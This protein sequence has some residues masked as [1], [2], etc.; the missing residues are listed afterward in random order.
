[1]EFSDSDQHYLRA[2]EGWLELNEPVEAAKELDQISLPFLIDPEVLLLR[3]RI[4]LAIHRPEYTFDIATTLTQQLPERAEAWF[5]LASACSRLGKQEDTA[6]ALKRCFLA[7]GRTDE[8]K[9]WQ[10][11]ALASQ[12]LQSFWC[13]NQVSL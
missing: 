1:V 10:E 5:Y 13:A 7:A 4:Y 3:C 2:A 6:V 11:R 8:E 9:N 12:D